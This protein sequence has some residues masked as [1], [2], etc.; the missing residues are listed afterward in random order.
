MWRITLTIMPWKT[1]DEA[2]S[3]RKYSGEV[4]PLAPQ[5]KKG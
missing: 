1:Q 5:T 3:L 4:L 2:K